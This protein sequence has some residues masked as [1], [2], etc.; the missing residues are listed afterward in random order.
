MFIEAVD[1]RC[2]IYEFRQFTGAQADVILVENAFRKAAEEPGHAIFQH[3]SAR[4]QHGCSG[5]QGLTYRDQVPFIASGAMQKQKSDRVA[6]LRRN[7][8]VDEA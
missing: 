4:T 8:L 5:K 3:P 2:T 7:E 1:L 6:L